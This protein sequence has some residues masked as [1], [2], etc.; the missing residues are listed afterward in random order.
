MNETNDSSK[1]KKDFSFSYKKGKINENDLNK[2]KNTMLYR[3]YKNKRINKLNINNL[4]RF[5][6]PL[7]NGN[8]SY[9]NLLKSYS[10]FFYKI[11]PP[12]DFTSF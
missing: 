12:S 6:V 2:I 11:N 8:S 7:L 9:D 10:A 1:L 3:N 4:K 5:V